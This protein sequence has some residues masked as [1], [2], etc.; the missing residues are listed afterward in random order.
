[1]SYCVCGGYLGSGGI[2]SYAGRWCKCANPKLLDSISMTSNS[3][4]FIPTYQDYYESSQEQKELEFA[5]QRIKQLEDALR[6]MVGQL[7]C[8]CGSDYTCSM[9]RILSKHKELLEEINKE[10][11]A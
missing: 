2:D 8:V 3:F 7:D 10:K 5:Y 1:M 6:D 11:E 4:T 9:C